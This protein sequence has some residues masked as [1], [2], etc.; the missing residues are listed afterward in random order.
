MSET[1]KAPPIGTRVRVTSYAGRTG[2]AYPGQTGTVQD[3]D[4]YVMVRLD[5]ESHYPDNVTLPCRSDELEVI[6]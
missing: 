6:E 5:S 4:D 3:V 1:K 2:G